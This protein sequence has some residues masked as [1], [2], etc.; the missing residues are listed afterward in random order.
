MM[1]R[2][3][4][5]RVGTLSAIA[6]LLFVQAWVTGHLASDH[7]PHDV[8]HHQVEISG[9]HHDEHGDHGH[10]HGNHDSDQGEDHQLA[11]V[12]FQKKSV[13]T[14]TPLPAICADHTAFFI[15]P[16]LA[17][18]PQDGPWRPAKVDVHRPGI[19]RGPPLHSII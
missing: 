4:K 12:H 16:L 19:P 8:V 3:T 11:P 1:A 10:S 2:L 7:Q 9:H 14:T 6:L 13:D 5:H 15:G 18:A 17:E